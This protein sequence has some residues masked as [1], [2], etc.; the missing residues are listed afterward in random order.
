M[1]NA[2]DRLTKNERREAAREKARILREEQRKKERRTKFL[3]QGGIAL[4]SIAIVAVV[5]LVIWSSVRPAGPG[6]HN[7]ASD[8]IQIGAGGVA[9]ETVAIPAGG[10]PTPTVPQA[11]VLDI[12]M[13]VDYM[14]PFCKQFEATNADYINGL[15]DNGKTTL[16]IYPISFLDRSSQGTR[17]STRA[18]N[19]VAC[20]A[21]YSPNQFLDVHNALYVNQPAEGSPGL[22]DDEII[23]LT[24][25]A[26]VQN[27]DA[28]ASCIRNQPY[29]AWITDATER[30]FTGPLPNSDVAA[31]EGTPTVL[32]N[33]VKYNGPV[34][35]LASFQ[36]FVVQQAGSDFVEQSAPTPTPTPTPTPAP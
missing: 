3:L 30:A 22:T 21:N 17:Y 33:G 27:A 31:V 36:A 6:P 28:V 10:K 35:D 34:D 14:C 16:E 25:A 24:E 29:R 11:G 18:A 7:M 15:L 1:T 26:N 12:R 4:A 8:G 2:N 19:A 20:V 9:T 23:A 13:Y 32:V 5:G